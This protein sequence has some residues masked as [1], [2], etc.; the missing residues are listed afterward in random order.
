MLEEEVPDD[1]ESRV[2]EEEGF[3][4]DTTVDCPTEREADDS[5]VEAMEGAIEADEDECA[6]ARVDEGVC[7]VVACSAVVWSSRADEVS[8]ELDEEELEVEGDSSAWVRESR[9]DWLTLLDEPPF[10]DATFEGDAAPAVV[11]VV[12]EPVP[13]PVT[14]SCPLA[15]PPPATGA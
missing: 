13:A 7:E 4:T 12:L 15:P 9:G 1:E 8:G 5:G 10:E 3:T 2:E 6:S 11:A 14:G